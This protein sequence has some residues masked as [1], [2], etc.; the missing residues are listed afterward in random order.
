MN[1]TQT[2]YAL[3]RLQE[4]CNQKLTVIRDSLSTKAKAFDAVALV[5]AIKSGKIKARI[6]YAGRHIDRYT[7]VSQVFD[8]LDKFYTQER[9]MDNDAYNKAAA[10]IQ[11]EYQRIQDQLIL[12]DSKE[13]LALIEAFAK[14]QFGIPALRK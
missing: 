7:D 13:A 6:T 9:E 5:A 3:R 8:G 1:K 2:E 11:A 12:G 14:K 10:P 4:V